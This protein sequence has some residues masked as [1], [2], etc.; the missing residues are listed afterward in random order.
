M[1]KN[2]NR[3]LN[4]ECFIKHMVWRNENKCEKYFF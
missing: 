4:L 2:E 1:V 3:N